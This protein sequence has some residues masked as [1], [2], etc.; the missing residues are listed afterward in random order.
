MN[1]FDCG[2]LFI[3]VPYW[4]TSWSLFWPASLTGT[5]GGTAGGFDFLDIYASVI[6]ASL[7]PFPSLTIG[8][9][10]A[11]LFSAYI[12]PVRHNKLHPWKTYMAY[13]YFSGKFC[14]V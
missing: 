3:W 12:N 11:G 7:F 13:Y 6:N 14:C 8:I 5:L 2:A 1:G 9:S 10:G 4:F